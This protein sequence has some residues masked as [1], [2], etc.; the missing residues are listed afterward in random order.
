M[1]I[2]NAIESY[3]IASNIREKSEHSPVYSKKFYISDMG[4]C[5]RIRYVK[6]KGIETEFSTF[7]YWIFAMGD[8]IHEFGYK[9]LEAQGLLLATEESMHTDHFTGRFDG[10]L[11]GD[12]KPVL[13]DFKSTGAYAMK[14]AMAGADND[15][16]IMQILTYVY[17]WKKDH[18]EI[19]DSGIIVYINKEIGDKMPTVAFDR[20][21]HLT[22]MRE[23]QIETEINTLT[24]YW[25]NEKIP[26]CTC[27]AWMRDY[28]SYLP[29]CQMT[30]KNIVKYLA[31]LGIG[32]QII[33]TKTGVF[34]LIGGERKELVK[35]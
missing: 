31:M 17:L 6:R 21:Y 27:P 26:P 33:S 30:E 25:V 22:S 7:V 15:E 34:S 10:L 11:K 29:F 13:F 20:E 24:D 23:K 1:K 19:S 3:L 14:K 4:K 8:M 28:N 18:P 9:A 12:D 2:A 35:I 5:M 32:K 16:N